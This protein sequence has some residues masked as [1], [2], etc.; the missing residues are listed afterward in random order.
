MMMLRTLTIAAIVALPIASVH[1]QDAVSQLFKS[2]QGGCD[3]GVASKL[4]EAIRA[5]I[6]TEVK[7]AEAALKMPAGISGLGCL[8]DLFSINLDTM[9]SLPNLQGLLKNAISNAESQ[10]CSMA[11]EQWAKVTEPLTAALQLP[12]FDRLGIPGFNGSTVQ[13]EFTTPQSGFGS[14]GGA[15]SFYE[16]ED[17]GEGT[18]LRDEYKRIYGGNGQ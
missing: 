15:P 14:Q 9:I 4:T 17:L 16:R 13:I 6:N 5:G 3:S 10:I 8:D 2:G 11:Q 18:Q 7:R 12:S 1:A